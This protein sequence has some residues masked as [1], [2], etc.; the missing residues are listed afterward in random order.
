MAASTP[1]EVSTSQTRSSYDYNDLWCRSHF[2]ACSSGMATSTNSERYDF[3]TFLE[4]CQNLEIDFL[5]ITWQPA[6][7]RLGI[8][9][10][11][12]V[13]QSQVNLGLS[14]AFNRVKIPRCL[15]WEEEDAVYRALVSQ[16]SVLG[17]CEIRSHS[18]I[19]NLVGV[20]WDVRPGEDIQSQGYIQPLR[21][22][23][24]RDD[25]EAQPDTPSSKWKVWPV[26]VFKK[27][28]HGDLVCF[29]RSASGS[30]LN[31]IGRLKLCADIASGIRSLHDNRKGEQYYLV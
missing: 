5:P 6:L 17:H 7:D 21:D 12:E 29:M 1:T 4:V 11:S 8:G 30:N 19:N 26:L 24:S 23:L 10:Q 28:K 9:A 16:A 2:S 25:I 14:F 3:I 15:S 27:S 31:I 22:V 18:N 20:C 13:L